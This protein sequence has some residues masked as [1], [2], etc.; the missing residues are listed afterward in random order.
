MRLLGK[1]K[2]YANSEETIDHL[3]RQYIVVIIIIITF[4]GCCCDSELIP[5]RWIS[6]TFT[7]LSTVH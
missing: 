3:R 4:V 2:A 1:S 7:A 6:R 5:R